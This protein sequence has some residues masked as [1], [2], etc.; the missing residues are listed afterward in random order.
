MSA[1]V[2]N[3]KTC[4]HMIHLWRNDQ[5]DMKKRLDDDRAKTL[6]Y[7]FKQRKQ[8]YR[9][10][11]LKSN[12][13]EFLEVEQYNQNKSSELQCAMLIL[14]WEFA[15]ESNP[16]FLEFNTRFNK[17]FNLLQP[18]NTIHSE[19]LNDAFKFS[20]NVI[21]TCYNY[22]FEIDKLEKI[23]S[24]AIINQMRSLVEKFSTLQQKANKKIERLENLK[25]DSKEKRLSIL[26][27]QT[28]VEALGR[29]AGVVS[30]RIENSTNKQN[31][32]EMMPPPVNPEL[33]PVIDKVIK[34][35]DQTHVGKELYKYI[36]FSDIF[37]TAN[38]DND[39][40]YTCLQH[41]MDKNS[42]EEKIPILH[43]SIIYRVF[44]HLVF[45]WYTQDKIA[46]LYGDIKLNAFKS[47]AYEKTDHDLNGEPKLA[48]FAESF[49]TYYA[50][51]YSEFCKRFIDFQIDK[52]ELNLNSSCGSMLPLP[53]RVFARTNFFEI[54]DGQKQFNIYGSN[55]L[56]LLANDIKDFITECSVSITDLL[57]RT[58]PIADVMNKI[59]DL[60]PDNF[61]IS[62]TKD[63]LFIFA[64][65]LILIEQKKSVFIQNLNNFDSTFLTKS[66]Y[67]YF[68]S[69]IMLAY[70]SI[71]DSIDMYTKMCS[72]A[73]WTDSDDDKSSSSSSSSNGGY[74]ASQPVAPEKMNA[75]GAHDDKNESSTNSAN[76]FVGRSNV[77]KIVKASS[78]KGR[79]PVSS[80]ESKPK[81]A[82]TADKSGDKSDNQYV[83]DLS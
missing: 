73:I 43:A 2:V 50:Y 80:G 12:N 78:L 16:T 4:C 77:V 20:L 17:I 40:F 14:S 25:I 70:N 52:T 72:L 28:I 29:G 9:Y 82:K 26:I 64:N 60:F 31:G 37:A 41:D 15:L 27:L 3:F 51:L 19:E 74:D 8:F 62:K 57:T 55:S 75:D 7:V 36:K 67:T 59:V 83:M 22:I 79:A 45:I 39:N 11:H 63:T 46:N 58:H 34:N 76:T 30:N 32:N 56:E 23:Q 54:I 24:D 21:S 10:Y 81:R 48:K 49:Y 68:Q 47:H 38:E 5:L 66:S 42:M 53:T 61:G 1:N 18:T 33:G 71:K 35:Y 6:S 13:E 65:V 69:M 44:C